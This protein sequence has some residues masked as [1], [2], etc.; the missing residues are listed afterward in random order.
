MRFFAILI[1]LPTLWP[2]ELHEYIASALARNPEVLA[3][4]K[5]YEAAL[6]RP[7]QER[8]LP[9]PR[10]S[11]G[12]ASNGGPLPG[13]GLGTAPTANIGVM[14][15]Q[16]IPYPGKL[17]LRGEIA[18]TEASAEYQ[19]YLALQLAVRSRVVQA[20]HTLHHA[21]V[22]RELLEQG[23]EQ[24]TRAIRV[25]E[26]RYAAGKAPQQD[27][28]KAHTQLSLLEARL[29]QADQERRTA[30]AELNALMARPQD[31]EVGIPADSAVQTL[32]L[33]LEELLARAQQAAPDLARARKLIQR[34]E[35]SV[36]LARKEFHPDYTVSAGYYNMGGMA[37]MYEARV[38]IPLPIHT[39]GRQ[40][41]A[42]T[43]QVQLLS[44]A[45]RNFEAAGQNLEFHVR[46]TYAAAETALRLAGLYADTILPQSELAIESS[47]AAYQTG[48][49]DFLGVLGNIQT[50]IDA[51]SQAHEQ[52]LNY[53]LA[54]ARLEELTGVSLEAG[55]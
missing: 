2:A 51:E 14:L 16:E 26:L 6:Q 42:L 46:E 48:A 29:V 53:A 18:A 34:G 49:G 21:Y 52:E 10:L 12:Y 22:M 4:Q 25:S 50:R 7:A 55:E 5:R 44:E 35:L 36:N 30:A 9:D 33:T 3:A 15:S 43:G 20:Y 13:Q 40:R 28:L 17:R 39:A 32:P 31:T 54:V 19:Q 41:P 38:E 8:S 24:M 27:I 47:L 37:P 23:K 1:F 11:M 45:R